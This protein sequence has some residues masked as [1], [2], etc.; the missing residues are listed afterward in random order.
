MKSEQLQERIP[1][2]NEGIFS[3]LRDS[4]LQS[5]RFTSWINFKEPIF[6]L[7]HLSALLNTNENYILHE[8]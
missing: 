3:L 2:S 5:L 1:F 7:M 4:F 8:P 6:L